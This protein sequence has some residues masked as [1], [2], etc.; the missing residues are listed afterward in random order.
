MG[1]EMEFC[2]YAGAWTNN[3]YESSAFQIH[4]SFVDQA[5]SDPREESQVIS[6]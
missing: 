1:C 4:A 3:V 6:S 5:L 2:V